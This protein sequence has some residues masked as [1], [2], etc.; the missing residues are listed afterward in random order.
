MKGECGEG[1]REREDY[2]KVGNV[3]QI[4][5][6]SVEPFGSG[7]S[8]ALGTMPVATRVIGDDFVVTVVASRFVTSEGRGTT[9]A[10][11]V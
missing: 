11:I 10:D 9:T 4:G 2:V 1:V 3:E 8:L 5:C 7:G 6:S